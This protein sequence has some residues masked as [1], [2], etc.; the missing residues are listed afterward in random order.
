MVSV[1]A[2][3]VFGSINNLLFWRGE[4]MKQKL[5]YVVLIATL[6]L[7]ACGSGPKKPAIVRVGWSNGPD[8][9]NPGVAWLA[10]AY[11][12]YELVYDSMYDLN[13]DGTFKLS[14]ADSVD[15]S[16]D[17][18]IYTYKIKQGIK[19]HDGQPFTAKDI[20][21]SYTLYKSHTD[22]P[23]LNSYTEHFV[24]SEAPDDTTLILKLDQAIPNIESRLIFLYILPEH[25]WKAHTEKAAEFENLEMV[26]TGPFKIKE[27]KPNEF[28]DLVTNTDYHGG[29]AKVDEVIYQVFSSPDVLVQAIKTGQVDMIYE[30]PNTSVEVLKATP[31]VKVAVGAPLAPNLADIIINQVAPENCP[32]EADGGVCSGHPAL[33]DKQVRLA[34]AYATDK[35]KLIDVVLVG[36][37]T[38]GIALIP[39]GMGDWFNSSIK[40]F[41]FDPV[42]ASKLLDDAG[43]KDANGDGIRDMPDGSKP[44]TFRLSWPTSSVVAP[45]LAELLGEMWK[46]IGISLEPQAVEDDALTAKCCPALDYDLMLWGWVAD[47]DPDTLLIIPVTDQIV[48]GYNETGY[49]NPRYDELYVQQGTELDHAKRVKMVWEM[50]Q[51]VHDD[52][53]Y[54]VPFYYQQTQAYRTD[55]F[56]GWLDSEPKLA[57]EDVTSIMVIEPVK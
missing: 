47:P 50:Q 8:S 29:R 37:G 23:T 46:Q 26:G 7:S 49:S 16:D 5:L 10:E 28:I 57:L 38:P 36:Y 11:T 32:S 12:I 44:L 51:I 30:M 19:W 15:V 2:H 20:A 13:L 27:Y 18:T 42:K 35:K 4:N 48:T 43:Y 53:V 34:L 45:R 17:D 41:E 24:S 21:F 40:D 52:V 25:I 55:R 3:I 9:L 54:I 31:N 1:M 14:M 33:R 22:F 39:D 56:K 6:V